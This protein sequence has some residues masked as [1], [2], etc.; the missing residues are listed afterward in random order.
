MTDDD[1]SWTDE[2]NRLD[3]VLDAIALTD[4][5]CRDDTAEIHVLLSTADADRLRGIAFALVHALAEIL[6]DRNPAG[7]AQRYL[8]DWRAGAYRMYLGEEP[9]P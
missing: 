4:A 9:P 8:D 2:P 3:L 1:A 7:T 5:M 6:V